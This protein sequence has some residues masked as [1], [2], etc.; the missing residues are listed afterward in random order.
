MTAPDKVNGSHVEPPGVPGDVAIAHRCFKCEKPLGTFE[1]WTLGGVLLCEPCYRETDAA[2]Q[3]QAKPKR[4]RAPKKKHVPIAPAGMVPSGEVEWRTF[5]LAGPR[6]G[7]NQTISAQTWFVA[8][9]QAMA[10]FACEAS[11]V[12]VKRA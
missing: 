3:K 2:S 9:A 11:Q 4:S 5:V 10:L 7:S 8:R 6:A 1:Q 12:E